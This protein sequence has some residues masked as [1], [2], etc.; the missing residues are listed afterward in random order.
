MIRSALMQKLT[1]SLVPAEALN[2]QFA[3]ITE[4]RIAVPVAPKLFVKALS[5]NNNN[6]EVQKKINLGST[7][8]TKWNEDFTVKAEG[9]G[10]GTLTVIT[11]YN[12]KLRE[13]ESQCKKFDLR[14]SVE[15]AQG[16]KK[17]EGAMRSVYIKIC[18]R[19]LGV[20]DAT[21]SIIDISMLTG[22]SPD[23]KDLKRVRCRNLRTGNVIN[24]AVAR[25]GLSDEKIQCND[26]CTK[27]YHPSNQSGLFNKICHGDVCRCAEESCF[28]QQKIEGPITL[29]K[30]MEEACKPGVDYGS[31]K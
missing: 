8:Q 7:L 27:F 19:F 16:V 4:L 12:S 3:V 10:Q 20:V 6:N 31:N 25:L 15:E 24:N 17:P 23:V 13:D 22:F 11:I 18:I 14:V 21:M 30:R 5:L 29:N 28:M 26:R 9:T 1:L 2:L